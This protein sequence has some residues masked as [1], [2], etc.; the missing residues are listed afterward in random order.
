MG[1]T[2]I[3]IRRAVTIIMIFS[4]LIVLGWTAYGKLKVERFPTITFPF[5]SI[6]VQWPGAAPEDVALQVSKPIE[7]A[8]VGISGITGISSTSTEGQAR[9]NIQFAEGS[10][11][12]QAATDV[13]TKMQ[14]L[15]RRL[16]TGVSAPSISKADPS[17]FP[18]MSI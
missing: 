2:K 15:A 1:L 9:V 5:I 6:S 7:D 12:N 4:A 13:Q 3:A 14:S 17:A 10:D 8:V 16:P 11:V 18:I